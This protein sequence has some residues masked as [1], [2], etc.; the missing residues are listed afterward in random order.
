[1]AKEM[2]EPVIML[3]E[4]RAGDHA[5]Y[6]PP[7]YR[8]ERPWVTERRGKSGVVQSRSE[9]A[10]GSG[11]VRFRW[12]DAKP[13]D[14]TYFTWEGDEL[15]SMGYFRLTARKAEFQGADFV[16]DVE[17]LERP[18]RTLARRKHAAPTE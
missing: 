4:L 3:R 8:D 1:M 7:L 10:D 18:K 13:E 2:I 6:M 14:E 17:R 11:T 12:S 16:L 5:V 15:S 9:H